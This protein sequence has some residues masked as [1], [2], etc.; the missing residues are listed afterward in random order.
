MQSEHQGPFHC[1]RDDAMGEDDATA[2]AA[3]IRAGEV[4]ALDVTKA[5]IERAEMAQP[6]INGLVATDYDRSLSLARSLAKPEAPFAGVP[7]FIKDNTDVQGLPTRHGSAAVPSNTASKTSPF[8][9]QMLAQGYLCLGK[10]TLPEFGFNATT[11]PAHGAATRNP[12]NL[13]YS[14]GASSGGAAALVAAGVVPVAHANDGGGSIR[15]PA[16]CCGLIGL[17]PTRGRVVDNEAAKTL[18]I[19]IVSDGVVTRSV[20]DSAGFIAAADEYLRNPALPRVGH[21]QGPSGKQLRIGVVLDS[22]TGHKTD[23]KTRKTVEATA[24]Y[25]EKLGHIIEPMNAPIPASFPDDFALYWGLLAFGV[26]LQGRKLMHPQFDKRQVDGLTNGLEKMFRKKL[27]KLPAALWRLKRSQQDYAR[28]MSQYDAVLTPVLGQTTPPLGHLSPTVPFDQLFDRLTRYVCFT[29]LANTTGA[30]AI[31]VP[32]ALT[33]AGL[34]VS[35]QFMARHG[36]ERT[37]LELAYALE[38]DHPLPLISRLGDNR[39]AGDVAL[40]A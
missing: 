28:H 36:D 3:R 21:V 8:A 18:P 23:P 32:M 31:S 38:A 13:Q 20:R 24:R 27:W 14:S 33:D 2:L 29:P 7:T 30:P 25:L 17:K 16:A 6:V 15:I 5:A 11:E 4:S 9:E 37:L 1:F 22:V 19:N 34:P 40:M 10:S 39:Y 35:V 12:W 26:K